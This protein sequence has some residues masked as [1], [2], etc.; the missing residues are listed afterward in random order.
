MMQTNICFI[1]A[2]NMSRSLIGGLLASGYDKTRV[3]AA[4][5]NPDT[6]QAI[7]HSFGITCY[8]DNQQAIE[9]AQVLV[10]A[11]KPQQLKTL[12]HQLADWVQIH[13]PLII[14]VAA[15]VRTVDINR[16][17]GGHQA[18]VRTM[19][20][21]PAL[22]QTGATGLFANAEVSAAQKDDAENILRAAG[23]TLWVQEEVQLDAVTALSGSGPA[24]YFLFMEAMQAAGEKLGLE[25]KA[26]QLLTLQTAFGAAKMALESPDDCS[27]L[28]QKVSSPNGTTER[29]IQSF[30]QDQLA[31]TVER[32]MQAAYQRA[33]QLADELGE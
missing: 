28:R 19:P 23:L 6:A 4:D 24:Y 31:A 10:L 17:L 14:S 21:T 29:A 13:K 33:Q 16:W 22:I 11:V 15:G 27:T 2:G 5:P 32:A 9:K 8:P 30:E 18:I 12:C 1:G 3:W 25:P 26:A 20:N 7:Q